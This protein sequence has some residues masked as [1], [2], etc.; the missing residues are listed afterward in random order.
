MAKQTNTEKRTYEV[1]SPV[2]HDR[3]RYEAGEPI[4]LTEDEAA[5]LLACSAIAAPAPAKAEPKK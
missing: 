4:E 1:L 2:D 3:E 5:P